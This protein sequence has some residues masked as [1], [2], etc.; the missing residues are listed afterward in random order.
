MTSTHPI[1]G[2]PCE[3]AECPYCGRTFY[4]LP[5]H[6]PLKHHIEYC[7]DSCEREGEPE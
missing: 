4:A 6:D 5:G 2:E 7:E 1:T 3:S